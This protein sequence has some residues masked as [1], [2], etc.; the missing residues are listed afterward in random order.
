MI[1]FPLL[2]LI[3]VLSSLFSIGTIVFLKDPRNKTNLYFGLM[4][5]FGC[6]W[7][8]SNYFENEPFSDFYRIIFLKL[9]FTFATLLVL[10]FYFFCINFLKPKSLTS[11]FKFVL[12]FIA[13]S[14]CIL[15]FT[16]LIIKDIYF[17]NYTIQF[18]RGPLFLLYSLFIIFCLC[19]GIYEL[20][21]KYQKSAKIERN[22]ILYVILGV[23]LIIIIALPLNLILPQFLFIPLEFARLGIYSF[24][25]LV[26]SLLLLLLA[27]IFLELG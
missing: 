13:F 20:I 26:Y 4:T 21:L 16:D 27:T 11:F 22:Q 5:L 2:L 7:I 6:L 10:F 3:I 17:E 12:P 25:F 8:L 18:N 24:L 23:I 15:T 9:D 1:H 14:F 19:G